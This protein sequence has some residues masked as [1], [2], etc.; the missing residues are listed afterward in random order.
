MPDS[1]ISSCR[2]AFFIPLKIFFRSGSKVLERGPSTSRILPIK[3]I[4]NMNEA[5]ATDDNDDG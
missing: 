2:Y 1:K 4:S 3:D 5:M